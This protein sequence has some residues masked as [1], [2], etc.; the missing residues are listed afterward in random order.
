[1]F[2]NTVLIINFVLAGINSIVLVK[3][4]VRQVV[5]VINLNA[6]V[7]SLILA[8]IFNVIMT[9]SAKMGSV[10]AI[11]QVNRLCFALKTDFII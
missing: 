9:E 8:T 4:D 3:V 7:W 1:M 2:G 10:I 5:H 11:K 6:W